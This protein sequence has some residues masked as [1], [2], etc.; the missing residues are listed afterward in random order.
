MPQKVSVPS[1]LTSTFPGSED[2]GNLIQ[3]YLFASMRNQLWLMYSKRENHILIFWRVLVNPWV[4]VKLG[5]RMG[6][7]PETERPL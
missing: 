1:T 6:Q 2:P 7:E 3:E 5:L 4:R